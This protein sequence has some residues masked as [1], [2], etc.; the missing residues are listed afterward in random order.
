M[1]TTTSSSIIIM[2]LAAAVILVFAVLLLIPVMSLTI[3]GSKSSR[4]PLCHWFCYEEKIAFKEERFS[5]AH[6]FGQVPFCSDEGGVEVF[7]SGAILLYLADAYGKG[8]TDAARRAKYT[9]WVVF[10]NTELDYLCFGKGMSGT[11]IN[12]PGRAMDKLEQ[13]LSSSD[14]LVEETF[15]VAD[16]AV[17]SYLNYVPVF[18]PSVDMSSRPSV[19]KYM[20]RMAEREAFAK[21]FGTEH[22]DMVKKKAASWAG[23]KKS[24][25]VFP[26]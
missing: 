12:K 20:L 6:P 5:D 13:I 24:G 21:A 22:A 2:A 16:V 3:Y 8:N 7:E 10:A 15:S 18:F 26:W 19:S 23:V 4:T 25:G 9:K 11:S 14:F 17:A 1:A